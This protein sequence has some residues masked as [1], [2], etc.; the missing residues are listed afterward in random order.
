MR[1]LYISVL[2]LV[3]LAFLA[4]TSLL[5]AP[6]L[7][8]PAQMTVAD[9]TAPPGTLT[10]TERPDLRPAFFMARAATGFR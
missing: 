2:A 9:P 8:G 7:S 1:R 4:A 3:A 6:M 10:E 5:L